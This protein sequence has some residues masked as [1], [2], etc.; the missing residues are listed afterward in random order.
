MGT[1]KEFHEGIEVSPADSTY[2]S[3][4]QAE[5]RV[6]ELQEQ[7]ET[8][9]RELI[10]LRAQLDEKTMECNNRVARVE[11]LLSTNY[12]LERRFEQSEEQREKLQAELKQFR[13]AYQLDEF[14]L[15]VMRVALAL[16]ADALAPK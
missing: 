12:D 4:K 7:L 11:I 13:D 2:V 6:S 14:R 1:R 9:G 15:R 3:W 8:S 5:V 16:P 10:S